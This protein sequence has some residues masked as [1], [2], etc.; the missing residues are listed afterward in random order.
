MKGVKGSKGGGVDSNNRTIDLSK[1]DEKWVV[2]LS[3]IRFLFFFD[4]FR[5]VCCFI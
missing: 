4:T 1:I 2:R 5:F 3:Q